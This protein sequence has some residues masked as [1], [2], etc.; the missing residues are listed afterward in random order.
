MIHRFQI[1]LLSLLDR[2]FG[3]EKL[4]RRA[5]LSREEA[6]RVAKYEQ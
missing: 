5:G 3:L 4:G 6:R 1:W 2:F